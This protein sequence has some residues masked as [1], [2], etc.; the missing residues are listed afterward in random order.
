M[1]QRLDVIRRE[2]INVNRA[3]HTGWWRRENVGVGR[4]IGA[5]R[6][7]LH[8][9]P[10]LRHRRSGHD[11]ERAP[12]EYSVTSAR[13]GA[14]FFIQLVRKSETW[15]PVIFVRIDPARIDSDS[16]KARIRILYFWIRI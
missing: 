16:R 3:A 12:I 9:N 10:V 8:L 4:E 5:K 15:G 14:A 2:R 13:Y 1:R 7:R 6:V 11:A